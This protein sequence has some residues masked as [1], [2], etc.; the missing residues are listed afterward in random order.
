MLSIYEFPGEPSTAGYPKQFVVDCVRGYRPQ[1]ERRMA[2]SGAVYLAA[3]LGRDGCC[4]H[5]AVAGFPPSRRP[6]DALLPALQLRGVS[7]RPWTK[8]MG[9]TEAS[10]LTLGSPM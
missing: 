4:R 7:Q 5:Q 3:L 9:G 1:A 6:S 8:T 10:E 2:A